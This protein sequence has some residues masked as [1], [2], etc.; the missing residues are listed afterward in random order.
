M[1]KRSIGLHIRLKKGMQEGIEKAS[2]L[3]MDLYQSF[4]IDEVGNYFELS[5]EDIENYIKYADEKGIKAVIH[6]AY[7]S[8]IT[9]LKSRGFH[10]LKQEAEVVAKLQ[11]HYLVVH[12]GSTKGMSEDPI[13]RA[14][15]IA[16]VVDEFIKEFPTVQLLI[17]NSPHGGS[18]Y[19][20]NL[21]DFKLLLEHVEHKDKVG[22]CIDTAHA[23]AYGYDIVNEFD[24]FMEELDQTV[25][26]SRVKILHLND[27]LEKRKSKIDKHGLLGEGL[28]GIEC[29]KKFVQFKKLEHA[30]VILELP[31]VTEEQSIEA[32]RIV[33]QWV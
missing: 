13:K 10:S 2:E 25:G 24:E 21:Q 15:A 17:E 14:K 18:S 22:F 31:K 5:A 26:F 20:G 8:G 32:L 1:K 19:G 7:W 3:G 12:S 6:S 9:R 33:N 16:E 30:G 27:T 11:Q 29:L 28:I 4:L 23:H